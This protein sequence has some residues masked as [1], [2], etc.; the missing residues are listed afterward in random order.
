MTLEEIKAAVRAGKTVIWQTVNYTVQ[1]DAI[2]Q[3]LI[4]CRFN[5]WCRGLT[6]A[7]G[8]LAESGFRVVGVRHEVEECA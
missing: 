4:V 2:G 5:G 6:R 7:D 8:T 3:W 1:E